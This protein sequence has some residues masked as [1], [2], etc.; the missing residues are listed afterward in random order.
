MTVKPIQESDYYGS[1]FE[2]AR[3]KQMFKGPRVMN[4]GANKTD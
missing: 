2:H 4:F 1:G 3:L